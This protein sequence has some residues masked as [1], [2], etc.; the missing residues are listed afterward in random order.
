MATACDVVW[1]TGAISEGER[2]SSARAA[3]LVMLIPVIISRQLRVNASIRDRNL[4]S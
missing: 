2:E 1:L 4:R 3:K